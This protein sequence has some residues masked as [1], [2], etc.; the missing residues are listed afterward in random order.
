MEGNDD[1]S[2][3]TVTR[4]TDLTSKEARQSERG[5][6]VLYILVAGMVLALLTWGATEVFMPE[7]ATKGDGTP[8]EGAIE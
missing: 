8:V 5:R 7:A 2:R 3:T 6:P 4:K 1:K